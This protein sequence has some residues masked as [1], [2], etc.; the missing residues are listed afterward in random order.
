MTAAPEPPTD[1]RLSRRRALTGLG[2]LAASATSGAVAATWVDGERAGDEGTGGG[3]LLEYVYGEVSDPAEG[4]FDDWEALTRALAEAP[5]GDKWIAVESDRSVPAGRWDLHGAGFRGDEAARVGLPPHG[6]PVILTFED[7]ARLDNASRH[8]ARDGIVLWSDSSSPVVTVDDERS[9]YFAD[10]SWVVSTD[11]AFFEVTTTGGTLVLFSFRT[12]SGLVRASTT[13]LPGRDRE[14]ID[15]TGSATLI[16]AMAS[17]N[18]IFDDDTVKGSGVVIAAMSPAAGIREPDQPRGG[19]AHRGAADVRTLL[20]SSAENVAY[21]PANPG[22]WPRPPSD[23]AGA[24]DQLA[25]RLAALEGDG[26]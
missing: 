6:N 21:R 8:F 3:D 11:A 10:D 16:V 5:P 19:F 24:L 4:R 22:D 12:G 15:H 25:A 9:Y 18:N 7:G 1:G 2:V 14:S 20:F 26:T 17:G 13:G 23:V